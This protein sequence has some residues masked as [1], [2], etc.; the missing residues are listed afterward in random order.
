[1]IPNRYI[2]IICRPQDISVLAKDSVSHTKIHLSPGYHRAYAWYI[3]QANASV[4]DVLSEYQCY[5]CRANGIKDGCEYCLAV[6]YVTML[7]VIGNILLTETLTIFL[8]N[9]YLQI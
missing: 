2:G 1:M 4:R 6:H 3:C 8:L 7:T 9:I 5:I